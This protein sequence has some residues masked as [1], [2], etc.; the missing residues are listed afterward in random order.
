[1]LNIYISIIQAI[2]SNEEILNKFFEK[3]DIKHSDRNINLLL[4]LNED[5]CLKNYAFYLFFRNYFSE[6]FPQY[7]EKLDEI[8][9]SL[10][11]FL[12]KNHI[13]DIKID[14]SIVDHESIEKFYDIYIGLW[15]IYKNW[16]IN[17]KRTKASSKYNWIFYTPLSI[18]REMVHKT[19]KNY[20]KDISSTTKI[21]D[22]CSWTGRFY[23]VVLDYLINLGFKTDHITKN[24][25]HAYDNDRNAIL[26]LLIKLI[27]R[28]PKISLNNIGH[29]NLL[30]D[31]NDWLFSVENTK[32]SIIISNPP[33][34]NLKINW[35]E[36]LNDPEQEF[37][38]KRLKDRINKELEYFRSSWMYKHT[39]EGMLNY[40]KLSIEK[41]ISLLE[42]SW[43]LCVICPSTLFWDLSSKKLRKLIFEQ[44]TLYSVQ[45]FKESDKIFEN[46]SQSTVIFNMIKWGLTKEVNIR[47]NEEEFSVDYASYKKMFGKHYELPLMPKI[48]WDILE[49]IN[50]FSKLKD[51]KQIRNRRWELDLTLGGKHITIEKTK[52][53]LLRGNNIDDVASSSEYVLDS[54]L[55]TK[56]DDYHKFDFWKNR[57]WCKQI[58][59]M[60]MK[61][62]LKFYHIPHDVILANSCNYISL[63]EWNDDYLS[64]LYDILNSLLLN[65]RF[66]ITSTNNH[67][68]NYELDELPIIEHQK[69]I[70]WS[71]LEKN[72][73]ICKIYWLNDKEIYYILSDFFTHEEINQCLKLK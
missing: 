22:F 42:D 65:R 5:F 16:S 35:N 36:S 9:W 2:V 32:F 56:S 33:Y 18:C 14:C 28:Y 60:D 71:E 23:F 26:I 50:K 68:N 39:V 1:M 11:D 46:V 17:I 41:M 70:D 15:L 29:K 51:V 19:L 40:Y 38:S 63:L 27:E 55:S 59:N 52:Y 57:L 48:W 69:C 62:R 34:L 66:K 64:F 20:K 7:M 49:K 53:R 72:L 37:L 73:A 45:Y 21:L 25:L 44:N 30:I 6:K 24:I 54:F 43:E 8:F 31:N 47:L 58:A 13:W 10:F 61:K 3:Y 67:V 12:W 4:T